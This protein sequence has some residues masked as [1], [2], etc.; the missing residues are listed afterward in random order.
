MKKRYYLK[1]KKRLKREIRKEEKRTQKAQKNINLYNKNLNVRAR[2]S[3]YNI[4]II[5][6][7][8]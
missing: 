6:K 7:E 4:A 8:Q 3:S 5:K 1:E 2:Y